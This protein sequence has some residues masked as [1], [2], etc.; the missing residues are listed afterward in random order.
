MFLE[1]GFVFTHET[2]RMWEATFAPLLTE[3]LRRHRY[4]QGSRRWHIDE[5]LMRVKANGCI[6]I[7]RWTTRTTYSTSV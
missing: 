6:F 5:T 2:V 4:G 7:A 3:R 1:R